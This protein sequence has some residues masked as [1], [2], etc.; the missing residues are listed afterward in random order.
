[1]KRARA[2][3]MKR[4]LIISDLFDP[5]SHQRKKEFQ[6]P[7]IA[8]PSAKISSPV[9]RTVPGTYARLMAD[10]PTILTEI[11]AASL[12]FLLHA[13]TSST[14]LIAAIEDRLTK[15]SR[16]R[17]NALIPAGD[18]AAHAEILHGRFRTTRLGNFVR[19]PRCH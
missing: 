11:G 16:E 1:M 7:K 18:E 19:A 17:L 14:A 6:M 9:P 3:D 10:D 15:F 13:T 12:A 2:D 4:A 8:E 5:G